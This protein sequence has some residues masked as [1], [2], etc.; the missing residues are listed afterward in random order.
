MY[1]S[2]VIIPASLRREVLHGLHASHQ[3]QDRTLG[4]ARQVVYW[5]EIASNIQNMICS[6]R[7]RAERL[8]SQALEPLLFDPLP[9]RPFENTAADLFHYSGRTFLV[10]TDRYSGWPAVST[11]G[12]TA[13]SSDIIYLLKE[14]MTD[15]GIPTILKT[16]GGPQFASQAFSDFC[17]QW[18]IH[19]VLSSPHHHEANGAV[20][21]AVK[22][23]K[24]LIT[25]T[26]TTG[27]MDV[28][29]FRSGLLEFRNTPQAHDFSPAQ[30]LYGQTLRSQLLTHPTAL[31]QEWRE[32]RNVLDKAA[33]SLMAKAKT[34]HDEHA[35]PLSQSLPPAQLSV[36]NTH[37][38]S[39]GT[40]SPKSSSESLAVAATPSRQR[41]GEYTGVT[42]AFFVCT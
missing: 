17:R 30:L 22:A 2:R 16:D 31:K 26:T 13:T 28:D 10:Y 14:W 40:R 8:P 25:K 39:G 4:R 23:M 21:A 5:P 3:G 9:S 24:A 37:T 32:Q 6:C 29:E 7:A 34:Q 27:R 15:K 36:C 33:T 18:G 42:A 41:A 20:E 11:T 38:P 19:H 12:R 35:C 1:G